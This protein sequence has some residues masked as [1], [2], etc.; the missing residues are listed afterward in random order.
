M[1]RAMS[2]TAYRAGVLLAVAVT[3]LALAFACNTH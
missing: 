3:C 2:R 1:T